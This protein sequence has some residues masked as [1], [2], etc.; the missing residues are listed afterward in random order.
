MSE[1]ANWLKASEQLAHVQGPGF[2]HTSGWP[3][4][5]ALRKDSRQGP[6]GRRPP[7]QRCFAINGRASG[8]ALLAGSRP[9]R[10]QTPQTH[11]HQGVLVTLFFLCLVFL[12]I[13]AQ[14]EYPSSA[15]LGL[16][17]AALFALIPAPVPPAVITVQAGQTASVTVNYPHRTALLNREAPNTVSLHTPWGN[18]AAKPTGTPHPDAQFSGYFGAVH[19]TQLKW[20]VPKKVAAGSYAANLS[21]QL[22]VCDSVQKMCSRRSLTLPITLKVVKTGD[23]LANQSVNLPLDD[24]RSLRLWP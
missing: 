14:I 1:S 5:S 2:G 4:W 9:K 10:V 22:F 24:G 23:Q 7:L 17:V 11:S 13:A 3:S 21:A 8:P 18:V 6:R 20:S 16:M 19:P 15:T 12:C